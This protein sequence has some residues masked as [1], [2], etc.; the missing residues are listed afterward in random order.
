MDID[1]R[2]HNHNNDIRRYKEFATGCSGLN[3]SK[4]AISKLKVKYINKIGH[5]CQKCKSELLQ[6]E[7]VEEIPKGEIFNA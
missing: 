2:Y 3:C 7:L 4:K 6:L 1:N 5:F